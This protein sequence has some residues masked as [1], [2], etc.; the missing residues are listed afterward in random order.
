[1]QIIGITGEYN[2]FFQFVVTGIYQ[3]N[4]GEER[5][6][7]YYKSPKNKSDIKFIEDSEDKNY[8]QE[9]NALETVMGRKIN[10]IHNYESENEINKHEYL[11]SVTF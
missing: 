6:H 2:E 7:T 11:F 8:D 4:N 5:I 3:L 10:S 9:K 1:M